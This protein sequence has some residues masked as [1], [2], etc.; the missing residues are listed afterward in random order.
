MP[1]PS[2]RIS[3]RLGAIA[4]SATLAVDAK[5]KALKAAG[6]PVIGFGAGEPDFP[7]PG[8]IV[9]AAQAACAVPRFQKYTPAAGLPELRQAVA[10]KTARDSGL[11][12]AAGQVLITNGGKQAVYQAFAALLDPGDEVL[13]PAPY[14]TTYPES[15]QLSGGVM[16][17]VVTDESTGYL[18]SVEVLE[19][20]RTERTKIL[21]F[22]SPSNP[23]GAVYPPEQVAEI[24]RWAAEHGL[25]VITDEIYEHLVYGDARFSSMP[26]VAPEIAGQ[27][28]VLNGVA[29][30]YAM[31]GW[32]V[33]WMIGPA[34]V[35]KAAT[36]FES[37]VTSNVCNV[38]QAAA[39][40]AVSGDLSAVAGMR[41]AFDRRRQTMT[42]LLNDIPGV[43][44]PEPEGAFYCYPS[45]KGLLGREIN[46][47]RPQSSAELAALILDEAEVAV[48]PGEAFG[49]PG[50][51]RLSCALGDSDLEEGV[52]RMGKLLGQAH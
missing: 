39:L 22:V 9:E 23:T 44:C 28:I 45:V 16:V 26:V 7:T 30:T 34:D 29:K 14:W 21:L 46:G 31:T 25:W 10:D 18:A 3:A 4:E 15:I 20:A 2:S 32:R 42:R 49:T 27:C 41:S 13:V 43:V 37:H 5:A 38:A 17:P 52:T 11:Q 8:Y 51:F 50:Y 1:T 35:I 12:V 33:G 36:N 24:G 19:A 47:Q 40:A 48:V 6:R